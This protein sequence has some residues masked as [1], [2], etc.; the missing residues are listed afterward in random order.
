MSIIIKTPQEIQ[1]M[2][3]SG[4]ILHDILEELK[5][6]AEIGRT[7]KELDQHTDKLMKKYGV[8][9]SFKGYK[10]FPANLCTSVNEQVVHTIPND[11]P[12]KD[13]DLLTIDCGVF[14]KDFHSD[15]A[16]TIL[17]GNVDE[18][19]KEFSFVVRKALKEAISKIKPGV[20]LNIVGETIQKIVEDQHGYSI[21]KELT[22]HGIGRQ[23]HEDPYIINYKDVSKGPALEEGMTFAI[24]P[25]AAMGS[26]EI[27][28]L[29]D[30][31]TIV[32][33]DK[34][35]ACQWE[36]TIAVT[37]SGVEILT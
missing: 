10:G 24:E 18:K 31:W 14:Y 16:I 17:V 12:L 29:D 21:V 13:G 7:T 27:I 26:G 22:G 36:H 8:V 33:A 20:Y 37:S 32:T 34:L 2:R 23:L 6:M 4:K 15:S 11:K 35:P 5:N 9:G 1:L 3:E 19:V 30:Q 28:T 25:I